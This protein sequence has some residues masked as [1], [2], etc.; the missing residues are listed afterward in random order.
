M[1][2]S[3]SW[4]GVF[5]ILIPI[6]SGASPLYADSE[7]GLRTTTQRSYDL[8]RLSGVHTQGFTGKDQVVVVIDDGVG[9]DHPYI[10]D[11]IIDG[12]CSSSAI[13]GDDFGKSGI[14]A[15]RSRSSS[16]HGSMVAGII[17]GVAK[18]DNNRALGG[19]APDTK[20]ISINNQN[21]NSDGL[22]AAFNWIYSIK[23]QYN[24]AA[25][26]MSFGIFI[27]AR[28]NHCRDGLEDEI[29][30]KILRLIGAGIS[31][32]GGAG[33]EGSV[34]NTNF[35]SCIPEVISV[36]ALNANGTLKS[37]SNISGGIT[38]LAP[39]DVM[40]PDNTDNYFLGSGTSA[41]T[42]F[43]AGAV[44]LLKQANPF[45]TPQQIKDALQSTERLVD[46]LIWTKIPSLD[47]TSAVLA[48]QTL[49]FIKHKPVPATAT[50]AQLKAEAIAKLAQEAQLKAEGALAIF[51]E[52]AAEKVAAEKV[53]AEKAAAVK[54]ALNKKT[55]ITCIKGKLIKK[56]I[57]VN[58]KCPAGYKKK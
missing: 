30:V 47:I 29:K 26:S 5:A 9:V 36:G 46:D 10:K 11:S 54:A 53:A 27:E 48:I 15:G 6:F 16:T 34:I 39:A 58:P 32:V 49:K 31:V 20:I 41:A 21:G 19:V 14:Q 56:V 33:N 13:C 37:Y 18:N 51:I 22:V 55:T 3:L 50:E 7:D 52:L 42:P 2:R 8:V 23:D 4:L 24:I 1:K 43:V 12:F 17:A 35:P 45:A 40:A 28:E 57:A 38:I 25:V 44:A